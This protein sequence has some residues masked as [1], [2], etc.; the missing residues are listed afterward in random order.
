LNKYSNISKN[1]YENKYGKITKDSIKNDPDLDSTERETSIITNDKDG[2]GL[3]FTA[4][5]P[6]MK[7]LILKND[8]FKIDDEGLL[9]KR[10]KIVGVNGKI[11]R[12]CIRF[13]KNPR[14]LFGRL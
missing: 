7:Y 12:N 1:S 2:D 14:K 5:K 11:S 4:Q 13:T 3:V 10:G 8:N 6:F 9:V